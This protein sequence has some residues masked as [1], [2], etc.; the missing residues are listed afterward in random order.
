MASFNDKLSLSNL[1]AQ[2][3]ESFVN[4]LIF[5]KLVSSKTT[6]DTSI[7]TQ[8]PPDED[9]KA[10]T[11]K[12]IKAIRKNEMKNKRRQARAQAKAEA[13][14][15]VSE[16]SLSIHSGALIFKEDKEDKEDHARQGAHGVSNIPVAVLMPK[17]TVLKSEP[18]IDLMKEVCVIKKADSSDQFS[19]ESS[20][21]D[22]DSQ[23]ADESDKSPMVIEPISRTWT[24]ADIIN[25]KFSLCHDVIAEPLCYRR[26]PAFKL[27]IPKPCK[28]VQDAGFVAFGYGSLVYKYRTKP[29][30]LD[31]V[32]P[33]VNISSLGDI[34]KIINAFKAN[35]VV[36]HG[37]N[38]E[39]GLEGYR[40]KDSNRYVLPLLWKEDSMEYPMDIILYPG[41]L[42]QHA[43]SM[44]TT[45]GAIYFEPI[46]GSMIQLTEFDSKGDLE[47]QII[48]MPI[49]REGK[50]ASEL[51]I[52]VS[53]VLKHDPSILFRWIRLKQLELLYFDQSSID[54]IRLITAESSNVFS[55]MS[56]G[57]LRQQLDYIFDSSAD[58]TYEYLQSHEEKREYRETLAHANL[59]ELNTLG[60][61][62]L[63][64]ARLNESAEDSAYFR[65]Y[66][67]RL[68]QFIKQNPL[69]LEEPKIKPQ[70]PCIKTN[71]YAHNQSSSK[72]SSHGLNQA[73]FV[74]T[75]RCYSPGAHSF[76]AIQRKGPK[77]MRVNQ[78]S[79]SKVPLQIVPALHHV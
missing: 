74:S 64:H 50:S 59:E 76:L 41:T 75:G 20:S 54:G 11:P 4:L 28:I 48:R 52:E 6:I 3:F 38:V 61:L 37:F 14:A 67:A 46:S 9:A 15:Q 63:L 26:E 12:Q 30:D 53:R 58:R 78:S 1:L 17:L 5:L 10:L 13:Q 66:I 45:L 19:I 36:I 22:S 72:K 44:D 77:S 24:L 27:L 7:D 56:R 68:D 79:D 51:A 34:K 57:K 73:D 31:F 47:G 35:G 23:V 71:F 39:E 69:K 42:E 25:P 65:K 70:A 2:L 33:N 43:R 60:L 40:S 49:D 8:I 21:S 18:L 55:E 32:V 29:G 16:Q 62:S